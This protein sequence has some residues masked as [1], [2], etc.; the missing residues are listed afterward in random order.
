[1]LF[2]RSLH[3]TPACHSTLGR[4][5]YD[6]KNPVCIQ[7]LRAYTGIG[8]AETPSP[9][10][11]RNPGVCL[12]YA[13]GQTSFKGLARATHCTGRAQTSGNVTPTVALRPPHPTFRTKLRALRDVLEQ[14]KK[15]QLYLYIYVHIGYPVRNASH[16]RVRNVTKH[17][18][19]QGYSSPKQ[20]QQ[21]HWQQQAPTA[22]PG[23]SRIAA[24]ADRTTAPLVDCRRRLS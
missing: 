13:Q 18:K 5:I 15:W 12:K 7:I 21:Q 14:R 19:R 23:S 24:P 10:M 6:K 20:Q 2:K 9:G 16:I 8:D 17:V 4:S 1:M 11:L 22:D 3:F